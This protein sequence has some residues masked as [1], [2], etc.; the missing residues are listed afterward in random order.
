MIKNHKGLFNPVYDEHIIDISLA[1]NLLDL[2]NKKE[3]IEEWIMQIVSHISFAFQ[4]GKYFPIDSDN[5]DDLIELNIYK[6]IDKKEFIKTSTLI[7]TLAFWCIKLDLKET[8]KLIYEITKEF[9]QETTLQIWFPDIDLEKFIY[10][11]NAA[12]QSGYVFAPIQLKEDIEEMKKIIDK[13][14]NK[15]YL[16]ELKNK[17]FPILYLISSRH[18][19][20]PILP[21]FLFIEQF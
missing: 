20:M 14:K 1:I 15:K 4:Q 21:Q 2:F 3:I 7:P 10:K 18:F 6:D 19:R 5:F 16:I 8:Y 9:Y 17:K 13:I 11:E 12:I